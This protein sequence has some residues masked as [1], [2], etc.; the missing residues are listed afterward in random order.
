M[1]RDSNFGTSQR[2]FSRLCFVS[3]SIRNPRA[4]YDADPSFDEHPMITL[5]HSVW[6]GD[7]ISNSRPLV[8]C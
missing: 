7:L 4:S 3:A 6:L 5:F 2:Y 8:L 1:V